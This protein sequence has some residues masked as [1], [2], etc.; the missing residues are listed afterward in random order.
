M[1]WEPTRQCPKIIALEAMATD[2]PT[3][4]ALTRVLESRGSVPCVFERAQRPKLVS[5]VDAK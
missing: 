4:A 2:G 3:M 5:G 1:R